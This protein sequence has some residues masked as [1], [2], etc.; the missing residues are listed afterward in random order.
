M[1]KNK[2]GFTLIELLIVV[3][4]IAILA[5]IAIPQ[6]AQYRI[7]GFNSAAISDL[8][9]ARTSEEALFADWRRYGKSALTTAVNPPAFGGGAAGPG[10]VIL[11]PG[12]LPN[13]PALDLNDAAATARGIQI[14]VGNN[15]RFVANTDPLAAGLEAVSYTMAAK[16]NTGDTTYGADS[17]STAVFRNT[18]IGA[19]NQQAYALLAADC[20]ASVPNAIDLPGPNWVQM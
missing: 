11:G 12:I 16:H 1:L 18:T 8:R 10:V 5:A 17:D 20:P 2:K 6:F 9:N 14:A 13:L 15:V 3:A 7:R 4:I 19:P